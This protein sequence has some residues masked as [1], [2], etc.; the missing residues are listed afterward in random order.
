[1][2]NGL[3][4]TFGFNTQWYETAGSY[5]NDNI[6]HNTMQTKLTVQ[7][8]IA[9]TI[10]A[11]WRLYTTPE[12][13]TQWN[14]AADT[15]HC[16][17]AINDLQPGGK[18]VWRME[19]KDG[20]FG[21]DFEATYDRVVDQRELAYT[22]PDGRQVTVTLAA[23]EPVTRV[24]IVFDPESEHPLAFQQQG[25]QAILDNFKQYAERTSA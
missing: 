13:I 25:W 8:D 10:P 2:I 11:V 18:M 23:F 6:M 4:H 20:S 21:F 5:F 12:H 7:A 17:S 19:A 1:L 9:A 14:F 24:T 16:P 22:M 15:W 3:L